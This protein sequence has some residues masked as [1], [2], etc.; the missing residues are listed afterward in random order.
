M[1][2]RCC[3]VSGVILAVLL[4]GGAVH[5]M[6][7]AKSRRQALERVKTPLDEASTASQ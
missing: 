5:C 3:G 2:R 1:P 6:P 4:V 7:R